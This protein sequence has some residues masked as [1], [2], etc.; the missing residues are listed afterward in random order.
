[1]A[2][3]SLAADGRIA[4]S[5]DLLFGDAVAAREAGRALIA[6]VTGNR[7]EVTLAG[8]QRVSSVSAVV[9]IEWQRA[10][11]AAGKTLVIHQA[12]ARLA[13]ILRLSG[14]DEV[15]PLAPA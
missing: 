6:A 2:S 5:G 11:Q 8:L 4:V 9:L 1:M 13:G 3:V 14:L 10:A 12:P 15:L 7:I